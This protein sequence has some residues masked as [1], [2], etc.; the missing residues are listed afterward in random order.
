[1]LNVP[2]P[3][4]SRWERYTAAAARY[5]IP[6]RAFLSLIESDPLARVQRFGKRALLH[7][8]SEDADRIGHRLQQGG[9]R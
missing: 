3:P 5:G 6:P 9:P 1:M 8:A 7:V 2:L 4:V